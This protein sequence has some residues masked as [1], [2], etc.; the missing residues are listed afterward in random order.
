VTASKT[1][2]KKAD[3]SAARDMAVAALTAAAKAHEKGDLVAAEHGYREALAAAPDLPDALQLLGVA[4]HQQGASLE[5][6]DLLGRAKTLVPNSPAVR[7]NLGSVLNAVGRH[8]EA[9][10]EFR[11]ALALEPRDADV[12]CNLGISLRALERSAE[13]AEAF[14]R[15][16]EFAPKA[17][18]AHYELANL[19][20]A[21]KNY[22]AC[23]AAYRTYV[24]LVPGDAA[25]LSN[26][27]YAI[28]CQG[29]LD[30]AEEL[31]GRAIDL[32]SDAPELRHNLRAVMRGQGRMD[33]ARASLH[34]LLEKNPDLWKAELGVAVSL[35]A[36]GAIAEGMIAVRD[37][38]DAFPNNAEIWNDVGLML[39]NLGKPG[40]GAEILKKATEIDPDMAMAHNNLG[41]VLNFIHLPNLAIPEL[42]EAL[43]LQPDLVDPH[44]NL[45]RAYRKIGDLDRANTF[46]RA[47]LELPDYRP[48]QF[49]NLA[50][51]FRAT[52]DFESIDRLGDVWENCGHVPSKMLSGVFL[53]L[54]VYARS[55][56]E[57]LAFVALVRRWAELIE[58]QAAATVLPPLPKRRRPPGEK[59]RIGFLS[60]DLRMHSVTRFLLPLMKHYDREKIAVHC[61]TPIRIVGDPIQILFQDTVDK[62][63]FVENRS[64]YE[65]AKIIRDDEVDILFELNGFTESTCLDALAWRAAPVQI[66]WLGYP[67]TCGL[68]ALDHVVLDRF[69]KP[70]DPA[71]LTEEPIIMPEAW[72]CFGE[73]PD[74]P[75]APTLPLDR[76]GVVT[77]GTLNNPYKYTPEMIA[78]WARIMNAVPGSR[79]LVVRPEASSLTLVRNIAREFERNGVS[80]DRLFFFD[81]RREHKNHLSYYNDIDISLDTFPLTGGTT[82]CEATWMGVPVVSLVGESFHQRISY[83]V[84]M[85]CGLEELC[86]FTP[87]DFVAKGVALANDVP[88]IRAMRHGLRDVVRA[89]PLCDEPRFLH[90]FQEMLEQVA[91]HHGIR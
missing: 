7:T 40:E 64:G 60:A 4:R 51:T 84:L 41:A 22:G 39:A 12:W 3:A 48:A 89:S 91:V 49:I 45:T 71:F 42:R 33:E 36:R 73:F 82:T 30:E 81:N 59:L 65:V 26:L 47:A 50:Q 16:I 77:F 37:L 21:N 11:A 46:A 13:A 43:R 25:S 17:S 83:S 15:A 19:H 14:E 87:E 28:Q 20:L 61:Y 10:E 55:R 29:R 57:V 44:L 1:A 35:L 88:R 72:V 86:A 8:A 56:E 68:K 76:N 18:K 34:A 79:F 62:F 2:R 38:L 52:C 78:L 70:E 24:S 90:Q 66:S 67:F 23:E 69:V 27:A 85:Q 74:V 5:A 31:F 6:L 58:N 80:P 54:L 9:A 75:V 63:T 32:A 53:D